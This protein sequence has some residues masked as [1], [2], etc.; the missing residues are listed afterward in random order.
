M[1]AAASPQIHRRLARRNRVVAGLRLMVPALGALVLLALG[2]QIYLASFTGRFEIGQVTVTPE[3]I[4]IDAP[5]YVGVLEDGS[6]YRVW[7][8]SARAA[9]ARTDLIDLF[10]A[11]LVLSRIDGVQ[12]EA[13]AARAQL[14]TTSQLTLV[15]GLADVADSTGTVGTLYDSVFDW[16]AQMLTSRGPVAIDYAD[17]STV[18]AEGLTYD[19]TAIVW[20][21]TRSRVTLPTTPGEDAPAADGDRSP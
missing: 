16:N 18:R 1:P 2:A 8:N 9:T 11:E 14:D 17:G 13:Q 12:L 21:F 10:E 4:N 6:V 15:P 7:A 5:E 19:A 20:T 3:A